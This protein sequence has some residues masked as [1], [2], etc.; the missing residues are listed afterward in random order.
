ML[1]FSRYKTY[2]LLILLCAGI[3]C[4][5]PVS[6]VPIPLQRLSLEQLNQVA[7]LS[8]PW[9]L[10]G[11][12]AQE[13]VV[14][15]PAQWE[16]SYGQFLPRFGAGIYQLKLV[17]PD[18]ALSETLKFYGEFIAGEYFRLYVNDQ[19][20]G[21]NGTYLGSSSRITTF[22]DFRVTQN[23]VLVRLEVKNHVVHW[24][25]MVM[26][27]HLGLQESVNRMDYRK[28]IDFNFVFGIFAF[29][30]FF[31]IVLFFFFR[32]DKI[33]LWFGLLCVSVATYMELFRVHN[34]EFLFYDIPL[35]WNLK[36]HRISLYGLIP[37]FSWYAYYIAEGKMPIRLAR[38]IT[39]FTLLFIAPVVF[40]GAVYSWLIYIWLP[41]LAISAL[42][43]FYLMVRLYR[44]YELA[45]F[46]YGGL[47][48]A[49]TTTNDV[50]NV[51]DLW[52]T[53]YIS[54]FGFL[55]FCVAQSLFIAWRLQKTHRASEQSKAELM[56]M[57]QNLEHLVKTRTREIADKNKE[58]NEM[59]NF[60]EEMV[61]MLVHDLKKP[62]SVL[63]NLPESPSRSETE[64][65]SVKAASARVR[66]LI[67]Q[68]VRTNH[69]EQKQLELQIHP[70]RLQ[71]VCQKVIQ[72]MGPW[73]VSKH[74]LLTNLLDSDS[75]ALI[76]R[77]LFERV[78]QNLLDNAI[79]NAPEH[80][81]IKIMGQ[82]KAEQFVFYIRDEGPGIPEH[83]KTQIFEKGVS[84]SPE[85]KEAST[86]LGLYF[87]K[88]VIEA[89][90]GTLQ[91]ESLVSGGA[92]VV[93]TLPAPGS[94]ALPDFDWTPEQEIKLAPFV[95][96]LTHIEVYQF[97]QL[98]PVL[99]QLNALDDAVIKT[100]TTLLETSIEEVNEE[101]YNQ[102][103]QHLP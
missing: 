21:H 50:G 79:K 76:D 68:M 62:L 73:A 2:V 72:V 77:P 53:A 59:A 42:Y 32:E 33:V 13:F 38:W 36:F 7:D 78:I 90:E 100:W 70:W 93:I 3:F 1:S 37:C 5:A 24:S 31:H 26:P 9:H 82:P 95:K 22:S 57:N 25:G 49:A 67:E 61:D 6:A 18:E 8:V 16:R 81:E 85:G 80:S 103:I 47:A 35:E 83:L 28:T 34:L 29:L 66:Q 27:L 20:V 74:I 51:F 92:E 97:S 91:L 23:E 45:P 41:F 43:N 30:A 101:K 88:Q 11:P 98:Q 87:C 19:L 12:D 14:T 102:L 65:D 63:I 4:S 75:M 71:A 52:H 58:L 64:K 39:I 54:R 55:A 69:G 60:K 56:S 94:V 84:L 17:L 46:V 40:P 15:A 86:G 99:E 48:W 89:H 96:A 10:T 44:H